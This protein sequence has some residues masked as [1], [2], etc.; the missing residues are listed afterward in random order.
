MFLDFCDA[1]IGATS[2]FFGGLDLQCEVSQEW[3]RVFVNVQ[4]APDAFAYVGRGVRGVMLLRARHR[5]RSNI[6][7]IRND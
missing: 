3:Q 4:S 2:H 1:P 6:G 5:W 7:S